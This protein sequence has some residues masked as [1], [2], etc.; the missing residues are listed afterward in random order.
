MSH[1]T[2]AWPAVLNHVLSA[3]ILAWL[4]VTQVR[5]R[6]VKTRLLFPLILMALGVTSFTSYRGGT[7]PTGLAIILLSLLIGGVGLAVWRAYTVRLWIQDGQV[8]RQGTGLTVA[9]WLIGVAGHVAADAW[10]HAGSSTYL[11][12]FGVALLAQRLVL[13]ARAARLSAS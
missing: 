5:R 9:L 10:T 7:A 2:V 8:W 1:A 13:Q 12:Y 6:P 4:L 3:A 11:L